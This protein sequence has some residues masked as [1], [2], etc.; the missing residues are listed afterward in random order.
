MPIFANLSETDAERYDIVIAGAGHTS[1][2][3]ARRASDRGLSVLML[4]SSLGEYDDDL[5]LRY[6]RMYGRG[7]FD[8]GH[9]PQHW[10]RGLDGTSAVWG[11]V[12]KAL[13]SCY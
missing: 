6:T 3:V 4:E 2:S 5:Q 9:W 13:P 10:I 8:G 11:V 7:H 12:R 1:V